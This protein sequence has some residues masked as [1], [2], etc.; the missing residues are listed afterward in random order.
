MLEKVKIIVRHSAPV[1]DGGRHRHIRA[2]YVEN[3]AGE[4]YK[5][6]INSL[7]LAEAMGRHVANDGRPHDHHGQKIVKMAEEIAQ[8]ASFKKHAHHVVNDTMQTEANEI[9]ERACGKLDQ[10]RECMKRISTQR[11]YEEWKEG[12]HASSEDDQM[13]MDQA[14]MEHYKSQFTVNKF[15]EN[16]VQ[17][18]PLIHKIM[19]E[20]GEVNLADM[21]SETREETC[22]EC[23]MYETQCKCEKEIKEFSEFSEWTTQV[24]EGRPTDDQI[25]QL[26]KL[27]DSGELDTTGLEG[28]PSMQ[29]LEDIGILDQDL[30]DAIEA[31]GPN[32]D[33]R[34]ILL[35]LIHI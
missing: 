11:G 32:G 17:Y 21:V 1:S 24:A 18:F 30:S 13:V 3:Q 33:M 35:S 15:N 6:P 8:L 2:I 29:A 16:L 14:T 10:L 23:G 28:T 26:K 34:T 9:L 5:C 27:L 25:S 19:Q 12:Q 4:R 20:I 7:R 31:A 22:D